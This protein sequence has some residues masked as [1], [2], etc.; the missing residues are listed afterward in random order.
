MTFVT[1][2][3][4]FNAHKIAPRLVTWARFLSRMITPSQGRGP[5]TVHLIY[6]VVQFAHGFAG[7]S[8]RL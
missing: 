5:L 3:G 7:G 4:H 8:A 2:K 1:K 6:Y